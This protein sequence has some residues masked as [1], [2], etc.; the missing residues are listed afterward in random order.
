MMRKQYHQLDPK[1]FSQKA[2]DDVLYREDV[3]GEKYEEGVIYRDRNYPDEYFT[4]HKLEEGQ[5]KL[6][7]NEGIKGE[8]RMGAIAGRK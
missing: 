1:S 4:W 5:K 7:G 8:W 2:V 6:P 3:K